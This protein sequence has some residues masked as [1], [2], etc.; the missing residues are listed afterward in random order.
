MCALRI[1]SYEAASCP[2]MLLVVLLVILLGP[3]ELH[4]RDNLSDNRFFKLAGT[5]EFLL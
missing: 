1:C 3:P 4:G 5:F 2:A